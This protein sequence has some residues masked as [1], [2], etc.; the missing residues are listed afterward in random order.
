MGGRRREGEG[1][2]EGRNREGKREGLKIVL[3][4]QLE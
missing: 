2:D 3:K 1:Q 4:S